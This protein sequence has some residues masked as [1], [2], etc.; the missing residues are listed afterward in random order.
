MS[1]DPN[2]AYAYICSNET[3]QGI[4]F[5]TTPEVGDLPLVC[6]AS[7]DFL[8]RPVPINR[9]AIYYACTRRTRARRA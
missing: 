5:Q 4:Q 6:D 1:F 3:I 9:Y 2:A 8:C 7:S